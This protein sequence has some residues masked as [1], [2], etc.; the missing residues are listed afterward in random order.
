MLRNAAVIVELYV[1]GGSYT[2]GSVPLV[3]HEMGHVLG[4][5][6]HD[7]QGGASKCDGAYIMTPTVGVGHKTWSSCSR[8]RIHSGV[9]FLLIIPF[10]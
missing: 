1:K 7:G 3:A 4:A 6:D 2:A 9:Y 8:Y 10:L 5:Q